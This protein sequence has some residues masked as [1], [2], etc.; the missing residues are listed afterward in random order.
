MYSIFPA[1]RFP[2]SL[3]SHFSLHMLHFHMDLD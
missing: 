2:F 1:Y 3:S